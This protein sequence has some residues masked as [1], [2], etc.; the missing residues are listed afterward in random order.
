[1]P[2]AAFLTAQTSKMFM[3]TAVVSSA[4]LLGRNIIQRCLSSGPNLTTSG[5][6]GPLGSLHRTVTVPLEVGEQVRAKDLTATEIKSKVLA[7]V[8]AWER[9]PKDK[10]VSACLPFY[11][12]PLVF[13]F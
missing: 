12:W 4:L 13:F 2:S 9:F 1:M 11:L 3:P 6:G 10:E 5:P 8:K 7:A